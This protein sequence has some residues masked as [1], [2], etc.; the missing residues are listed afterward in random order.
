MAGGTTANRDAASKLLS[1]AL[2][3]YAR[4]LRVPRSM[5]DIVYIDPELRPAAPDAD[6]LG[7]GQSLIAQLRS[8][9]ASNRLYEDLRA[10]LAHYR[11]TWSRLPQIPVA[12]GPALAM[13]SR[14]ERVAVLR[15]RLGVVATA[16]NEGRYDAALRDAVLKFRA[17]H[18]LPARP[19][20]DGEMIAALNRGAAHYEGVIIAN[21]D[22]LRGLPVDGG[23][24][25]LVDT[26]GAKAR[27]IEGGQ[28]ADSMRVVVGKAGMET[29]WLAGFIRY[30]IVNPY[31]NVPP[32]LVRN[33]IAPAVLRQGTGILKQR[34]FV[35]SPDWQSQARVDPGD[36]DWQAVAEGR[37][38]IWVRQLPG[39]RN[40]MGDVKFMLPN[41]LGIYLHDTPDK[42]LFQRSDRRLSSGCV[43]VE[44]AARLAQWLF[45]RPI[46]D[47]DTAPDK[48]VDLPQP[49]PVF[50]TYLTASF[51]DGRVQFLPDVEKR[52]PPAQQIT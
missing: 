20:V 2:S 24:Y 15:Q 44:D 7:A 18:G 12:D 17:E 25:V 46:V 31:W 30:A 19:V 37:A 49:V 32:D 50:I 36:V 8:L 14:G 29:P 41:D 52:D 11:R 9:H 45:G 47:G 34:N 27:L 3:A 42:T 28:E 13:G 10:G 6:R 39:G 1:G 40:M 26:A 38:N 16:M 51:E 5:S 48:R 23:R 4:D 35:L 22:R 33:S 43:R 21:L